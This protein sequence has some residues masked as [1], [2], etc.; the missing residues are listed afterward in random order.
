MLFEDVYELHKDELYDNHSIISEESIIQAKRELVAELEQLEQSTG[1]SQHIVIVVDDCFTNK[2]LLVLIKKILGRENF[3]RFV[4]V[5]H[6]DY[7]KKAD[8]GYLEEHLSM[9]HSLFILG[10]SL[11]DTYHMDYSH[12]S[13]YLAELIQQV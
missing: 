7:N 12:Y 6:I 4:K 13:S 9:N 3:R 2:K 5:V 11:S 10:G 1:E 8:N